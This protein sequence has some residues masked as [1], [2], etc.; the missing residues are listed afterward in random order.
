MRVIRRQAYQGHAVPSTASHPRGP[1]PA[2]VL[3]PPVIVY[4]DTDPDVLMPLEANAQNNYQPETVY[5][6]NLCDARVV[7]SMLD[8]HRC[9]DL[10]G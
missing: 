3:A 10:H 5:V 7:E 6:C 1:F 8:E 4:D 9:E 2:E